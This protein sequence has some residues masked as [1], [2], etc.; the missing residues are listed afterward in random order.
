[1]SDEREQESR[2]I[3]DSCIKRT[4]FDWVYSKEI[5]LILLIIL[6]FCMTPVLFMFII[7]FVILYF[8]HLPTVAAMT[9]TAKKT[10]CTMTFSKT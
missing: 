5:V 8:L 6:L 3:Q 4:V 1:M 10:N 9:L 2:S 7:Y